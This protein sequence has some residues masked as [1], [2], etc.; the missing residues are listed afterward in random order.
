VQT[1]AATLCPSPWEVPNSTDFCRLEA[2]LNGN[3][4][5]A[6]HAGGAENY[7]DVNKWGGIQ[8]GRCDID[9]SVEME[10]CDALYWSIDAAGKCLQLRY[11]GTGISC[12]GQERNQV[13]V[14]VG[15]DRGSG[16]QVRCVLRD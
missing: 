2:I 15:Y 3:T 8:G 1:N 4:T 10:R 7:L 13:S 16:L 5:C 9:V 12:V 11:N 6:S 14:N